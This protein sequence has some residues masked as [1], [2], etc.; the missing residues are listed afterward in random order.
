MLPVPAT[1]TFTSP[2]VQFPL[3]APV[4][5]LVHDVALASTLMLAR[6]VVV[7]SMGKTAATLPAA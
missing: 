1:V 3:T 6:I 7:A 4:I 2:K 5:G